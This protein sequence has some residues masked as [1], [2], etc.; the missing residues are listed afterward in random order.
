[1]QAAEASRAYPVR[2]KQPCLSLLKAMCV[3]TFMNGSDVQ[4]GHD[5]TAKLRKYIIRSP[6]Q[7]PGTTPHRN[8]L[9]DQKCFESLPNAVK[10][11]PKPENPKTCARI[12]F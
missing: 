4:E 3:D 9:Y 8:V 12:I 1:M 10:Q 6:K 11:P 2:S 7:I 5:A